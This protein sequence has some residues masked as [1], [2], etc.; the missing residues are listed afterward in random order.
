MEKFTKVIL[1]S[2]VMLLSSV[3]VFAQQMQVINT[4]PVGKV[5]K[6][7]ANSRGVLYEQT[8]IGTNGRP[9]QD[10][11]AGFDAYDSWA[12]DDFIVPAGETWNIQT[13][14]AYGSGSGPFNLANL[15]FYYDAGGV[16]GA[17][18]GLFTG[19]VPVDNTETISVNLPAGGI[20]PS[21]VRSCGGRVFRLLQEEAGERPVPFGYAKQCRKYGLT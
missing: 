5:I 1:L 4:G 21:R 20:S 8:D 12:A 2:V 10:F 3:L 18:A 7:P 17:S 14:T 15:E 16:P 9:S 6:A 11:E 13:V 19:L